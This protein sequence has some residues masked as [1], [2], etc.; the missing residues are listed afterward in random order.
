MCAI[1]GGVPKRTARKLFFGKKGEGM[2]HACLEA[3]PVE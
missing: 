1:R 3:R 2:T